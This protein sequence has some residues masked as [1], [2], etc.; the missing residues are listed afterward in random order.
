MEGGLPIYE[1]F[2]SKFEQD[3]EFWVEILV[4]CRL[5]G[6]KLEQILDFGGL[7]EKNVYF[8]IHFGQN[9]DFGD[10]SF[11][12]LSETYRVYYCTA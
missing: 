6:F 5:F 12:F 1:V 8:K 7:F 9:S 4:R 10:Q 2:G 11:G 3:P